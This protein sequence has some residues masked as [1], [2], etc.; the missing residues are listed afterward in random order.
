[1]APTYELAAQIS[2]ELLFLSHRIQNKLEIKLID[3]MNTKVACFK[4]Q[5]QFLD[6]LV[7]TPLKFLKLV[8][9]TSL[10]LE[11]VEFLILDEADKYF[12][13]VKK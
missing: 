6:I 9:K 12:E 2:R 1:M 8:S 4:E 13:L 11:T 5:I 7:T 10:D 3:K